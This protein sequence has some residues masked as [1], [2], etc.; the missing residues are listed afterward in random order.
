[1]I[2]SVVAGC[3]P[4]KP[5]QPG[6]ELRPADFPSTR[7]EGMPTEAN[8]RQPKPIKMRNPTYP[9]ELRK[10][11]I[12]GTVIVEIIVDQEGHVADVAI[13]SSPNLLFDEPVVSAVREWLFEPGLRDGQPV[14]SKIRFPI[15][16]SL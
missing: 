6:G 7:K 11:K 2:L 13:V 16:F 4:Y 9:F 8:T 15:Q 12:T 14:T 1:M 10:Q 3:A 5:T